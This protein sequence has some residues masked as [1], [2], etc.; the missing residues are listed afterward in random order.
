MKGIIILPIALGASLLVAGSVIFGLALANHTNDESVTNTHEI[1]ETFDKFDIKTSIANIVFEKSTDG[2]A[3]VVCEERN[4]QYH[5]VE[6]VSN[7]LTIKPVDELKWYEKIFNFDFSKKQVTIYIP[8]GTY[9]NLKIDSSTGNIKVPNNFT[10]ASLDVEVDT[11]DVNINSEVSGDVKVHS[12]TGDITLSDMNPAAL[13]IKASTGD[14]IAKDINVTGDVVVKT[15]TGKV[16]LTNFKAASL[17]ANT[18]TGKV[19]LNNTII[20]GNLK[21]K[22][23]TGDVFFEDCDANSIKV[24][25]DTGD[26]RGTFLSDK[27]IYAQ[28][29]TGRVNVPRLTSG[30]M[31]EIDTDTG[32]ITISIK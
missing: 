23:D 31:C 25:T 13:D 7:T 10:F 29:K 11:G 22:T 16:K 8:E 12:H 15:N 5:T 20:N 27:V 30:G 26:V 14:F 9:S 21:V 17:D 3:K 4:K 2:N 6:V 28:S 18:N 19:V 1:T 24:E 32:D